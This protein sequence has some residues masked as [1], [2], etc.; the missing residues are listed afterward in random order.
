M[1]IRSLVASRVLGLLAICLAPLFVW[2]GWWVLGLSLGMGL[3]SALLHPS[4]HPRGYRS[5]VARLWYPVRKRF[6]RHPW[7]PGAL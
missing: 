4:F 2:L 3:V 5:L 6:E 1:I 7:R